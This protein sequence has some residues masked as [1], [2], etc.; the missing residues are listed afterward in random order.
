M[1]RNIAFLLVTCC[2]EQTRWEILQSVVENLN[3]CVMPHIDAD[4]FTVFD[5]ASTTPNIEPYLKRS[6]KH[7]FRSDSN[8]GYWSA[9]HWWLGFLRNQ[10]PKYV[11]I[12][13]SD[14]IHFESAPGHLLRCIEFLNNNPNFGS[15]RLHEWTYA[16]RHLYNKDAP[17]ENSKR[18]AWRS[19][20]NWVT[21]RPVEIFPTS[22][23][24][25]YG[26]TFLTQLVAVNR[27]DHMLT[28]FEKI[29][30]QQQFVEPEFQSA[31][32]AA[33]VAETGC[34]PL[35]G[36]VDGGI[37]NCDLASFNSRTIASSYTPPTRLAQLGYRTTR[38]SNIVP[39]DSY[40]VTK[41]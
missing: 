38:V 34:E 39:R 35:T 3:T 25:I 37:F 27:Y 6:F 11:Y 40:V 17:V 1:K 13:E 15:I 8:V 4:A 30:T 22:D 23:P 16:E 26:T 14:L 32:R 41:L 18:T 29:V 9:I 2:L 20:T 12:I 10:R 24:I 33:C 19:H 7:V 36:I 31:Y 28:A 5:N 21:K